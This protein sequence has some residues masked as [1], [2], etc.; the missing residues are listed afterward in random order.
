V[1]GPEN[2]HSPFAYL[3][4]HARLLPYLEQ[5]QV[6]HQTVQAFQMKRPFTESPPHTARELP[7]T[8]F[9]CPADGRAGGVAAFDEYRFGMT[10]Y[11]GVAG[12]NSARA[13][14]SLYLDS[15][16]RLGDLTDGTANTIL[17]GERPTSADFRFGWWYGGWGQNKDG[18]C[19]GVLGVRTFNHQT[20]GCPEGPY[21]FQ[22]GLLNNQC[23][24]FH[25]WSPHSGGANFA[26][27]DGS[28]RF[29]SYSADPIM[30]ALAT[31]AGGETVA[32]P[33]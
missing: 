29:L 31:R 12:I 30:P 2:R 7:I 18:E 8:V 24:M 32:V 6:W 28:V 26:F 25:F 20:S 15:N 5:E 22:P 1:T 33:E 14:G 19:D 11:L 4:W 21:S 9:V 17:V 23:D 16:H 27:A 10:S 13:D 3:N